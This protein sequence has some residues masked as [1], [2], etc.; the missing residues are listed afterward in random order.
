[1]LQWYE[2]R[3]QW[4]KLEIVVSSSTVKYNR[5]EK[6]VFCERVISF[7]QNELFLTCTGSFGVCR[8]RNRCHSGMK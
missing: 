3:S 8:S 2:I 1:M 6:N 5:N 7:P 4:Y